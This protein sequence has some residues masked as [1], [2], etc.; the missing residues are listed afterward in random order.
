MI[1][2]IA[3]IALL[4]GLSACQKQ[5]RLP[6]EERLSFVH[7]N[8]PA[9]NDGSISKRLDSLDFSFVHE[10]A[11]LKT[12]TISIPLSL[13]G[14]T[15][16]Y[17]R[18]VNVLID[19]EE[20][21]INLSRVKVRPP[22]LRTDRFT[23]TLYIS[24]TRD[25][26]MIEKT[27]ALTL[28]INQNEHFQIGPV[29]KSVIKIFVSDQLLIPYWWRDWIDYFGQYHPEVYRAWINIYKIGLDKSAPVDPRDL[30]NF[31][32]N[33]MPSFPI[34]KNYPVTFFYIN[35][36]KRYFEEN[37]V[38]PEGDPTKPRIKLP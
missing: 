31:A 33:N 36:L 26:S 21:D 34:P 4:V 24:I 7:F 23:D 17:D 19:K 11:A 5:N 22:V 6:F 18:E 16:P 32:W 37:I 28:R 38:Y 25:S 14:S 20:S 8:L 9:I 15:R 10:S 30:P 29:D 2:V 3:L 1:K 35:E 12:K 27:Y 13:A